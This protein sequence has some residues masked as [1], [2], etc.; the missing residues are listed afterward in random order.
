[1]KL[2][3]PQ[4]FGL[5]FLCQLCAFIAA[6]YMLLA[7]IF[8]PARAIRMAVSYDQLGNTVTNGHED[9]TISSRAG[10]AARLNKSWACILCK[11]LDVFD[12]NHCEK[13]IGK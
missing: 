13:S 2:E 1:M 7:I 12:K 4:L 8:K 11:F 6:V 5:W 3:R 10:R 9:E